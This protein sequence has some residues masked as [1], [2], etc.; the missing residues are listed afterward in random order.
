MK[1]RFIVL[2]KSFCFSICRRFII[3][4]IAAKELFT[5]ELLYNN[6]SFSVF[7]G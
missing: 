3:F 7:G 6:S 4:F 2:L 5:L 1:K